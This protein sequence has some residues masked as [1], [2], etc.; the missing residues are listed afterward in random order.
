[1]NILIQSLFTKEHI[2]KFLNY[3][4]NT[5]CVEIFLLDS[6]L[7]STNN[8]ILQASK[9]NKIPIYVEAY[10]FSNSYLSFG[11]FMSNG[12]FLNGVD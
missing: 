1:M 12:Q 9:T 10:L 7:S 6:S 8:L 3:I 5:K 4:L 2:Y 11:S